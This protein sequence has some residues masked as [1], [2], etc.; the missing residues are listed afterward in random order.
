LG[1]ENL[2]LAYD[3][4]RDFILSKHVAAFN[5]QF[6]KVCP[7]KRLPSGVAT[8]EDFSEFKE[9]EVLEICRGVNIIDG[10]LFKILDEKLGRRNVAAHPS[11][12]VV[13]QLQAEDF[14]SDLVSNVVL[15]LG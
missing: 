15:K 5:P 11:T 3:H 8:A 13:T 7:K 4:L 12:V 1:E 2:N 14:I 6:Q 10:N 9:S